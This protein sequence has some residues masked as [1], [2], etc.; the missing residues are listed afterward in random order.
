MYLEYHSKF[1]TLQSAHSQR[2]FF[3]DKLWKLNLIKYIVQNIYGH[4][5]DQLIVSE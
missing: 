5:C 4:V 1:D 3:L 2:K